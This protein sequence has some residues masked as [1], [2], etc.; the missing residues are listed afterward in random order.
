MIPGTDSNISLLH[1]DKNVLIRWG[2]EVIS[3]GLKHQYRD[4]TGNSHQSNAEVH[5]TWKFTSMLST[6][7]HDMM[8]RNEFLYIYVSIAVMHRASLV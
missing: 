8:S 2:I 7:K 4:D 5:K 3:S 1:G 6:R